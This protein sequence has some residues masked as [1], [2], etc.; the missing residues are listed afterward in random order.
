MVELTDAA[1][2]LDFDAVVLDSF[3]VFDPHEY[4]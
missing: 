2:K 4:L 3:A 1:D